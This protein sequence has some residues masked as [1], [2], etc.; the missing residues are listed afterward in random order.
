MFFHYPEWIIIKIVLCC[1]YAQAMYGYIMPFL[2][3]ITIIANTLIVVVLSKRHM[4]TPTNFVL[5]VSIP[6]PRSKVYFILMRGL[7]LSQLGSP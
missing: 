3:V 1:R 4:R 7:W 6:T 5:M 2:L